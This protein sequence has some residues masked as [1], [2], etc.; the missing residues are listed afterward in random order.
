MLVMIDIFIEEIDADSG[1]ISAIKG[2]I[3]IT[4]KKVG[5]TD[6]TIPKDDT[7][8]TKIKFAH[9]LKNKN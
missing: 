1:K 2:I 9:L 5:F 8:D 7:L 6:S 3:D 4:T